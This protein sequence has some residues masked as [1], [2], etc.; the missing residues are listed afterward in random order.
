MLSLELKNKLKFLLD[1]NVKKE[2]LQF[3]KQSGFD[4]IFKPKGL[5]NGVLAEYSKLEQRILVTND[6][7]FSK[8]TK[9]KIF[10]V[11][12]LLIPQDKPEILV[13]S[14]SRLLE[15][16]SP[17]NFKGNLIILR[18]KDFKVYPLPEIINFK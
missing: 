11:I 1:E 2:L 9:E 18:E 12:W 14:F 8:V 17:E 5:S 10:S 6:G 3:L 7:D 4:I 13:R 15:E 16:N